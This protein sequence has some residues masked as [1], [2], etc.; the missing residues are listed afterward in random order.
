M[1]KYHILIVEDEPAIAEV[2]CAYC[3]NAGYT[4]KHLDSGR[5]V[6]NY[7]KNNN[8]DL[9]LLDLM[10]P[11]V[12]GITLCKSTRLFS[13]IPIIMITAK[14]EEIDRL[15]GLEIGA[16][17]YICKPFSPREVIARIKV[18]LKRAG[19][20]SKNLIRQSGFELDIEQ[21]SATL[22]NQNLDLTPIEFKLLERFIK[23]INKV[24]SRQEIMDSVYT[25]FDDVSDR[26]IDTH[27]KNIRKKINK[28]SPELNPIASVY[29]VGYKITF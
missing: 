25:G 18:I 13:E 5:D 29:G 19:N 14:N 12:D 16:D 21:Y 24:F 22:N 11:D 2:L 15:I 4:V 17:D 20:L 27:V 28:I 26:N 23:N 9:I 6:I 3:T 8:V 1:I 7:L 10:L